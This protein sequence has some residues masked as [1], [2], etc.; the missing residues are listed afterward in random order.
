M[1]R[2]KLLRQ[3]MA[4]VYNKRILRPSFLEEATSLGAVI[5]GGIGEDKLISL[6]HLKIKG[7]REKH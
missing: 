6:K 3:I 1:G 5:V 4:D 2:E 7:L